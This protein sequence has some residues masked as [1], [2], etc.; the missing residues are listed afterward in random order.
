[1]PLGVPFAGS[2]VRPVKAELSSDGR[3][4]DVTV[5]NHDH[6]GLDDRAGVTVQ[7]P[8]GATLS[9]P[10]EFDQYLPPDRLAAG[11]PLGS[12]IWRARIPVSS[13]PPAMAGV[14][15]LQLRVRAHLDEGTHRVESGN[16]V[17][18]VR[19]PRPSRVVLPAPENAFGNSSE[20][21][22]PYR[23]E[24]ATELGHLSTTILPQETSAKTY[25][26]TS[27][28]HFVKEITL[29][30]TPD[31]ATRLIGVAELAVEL[32]PLFQRVEKHGAD[33]AQSS[34]PFV[35]YPYR[36]DE[37]AIRVALRR[38]TDGSFRAEAP[39]GEAFAKLT[40]TGGYFTH[41]DDALTGF[42]VRFAD[43]SLNQTGETPR[44]EQL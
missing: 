27:M 38:Q 28:Q 14:S 13:L 10:A 9:V 8:N 21:R 15:P 44:A 7:A 3:S 20:F 36:A 1:M 22:S 41:A 12:D 31:A 17:A 4:I 29:Q 2:H 19:S 11:A 30:P 25:K 5:H 34:Q 33:H 6:A 43:L 23:K 32:M 35:N 24:S 42:S 16:S 18:V 26:D 37:L 40:S 39:S